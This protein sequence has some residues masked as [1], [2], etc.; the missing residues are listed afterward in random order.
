VS[1]A[2]ALPII[3]ACIVAFT[4]LAYIVLDGFDLGL[5]ILFAAERGPGARDVLVNTVAPVWDGNETWLVL[6]GACLYGVFPIAYGTILP[7]LYPPIIA[8]LLALIFRGVA[9]E[10]RFK[11]H[12]QRQRALWDLSFFAGSTVAAAMQGIILG[13]LIQGIEV[14]NR[15]YAGGWFDWLT[16]FSLVC[17]FAVVV[18]Y[19]LLGACWLVWRTEG[20]LQARARGYAKP[21]A[22]ITVAMIIVVSLWTP[23]LHREYLRHWYVWP[24][25]LY[26]LPV[27][28]LVAALVVVFWRNITD[29]V[30][31]LTP[32][33]CV[34]GWF[35]LCFTG[36][37]ISIWPWIVPPSID[38]WQAASP[39][40]SQWFLLVGAAVLIPVVLAYTGYAYWIF[41]GK[42]GNETHYH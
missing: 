19:A 12:T 20:V 29:P 25:I 22:A 21:L 28:V 13:G 36:L 3:W 31:H 41:R 8:M 30:V 10:F 33:L 11:V 16:A 15:Q 4:V 42:V 38:I 1:T 26:V 7:A 14:E 18:G 17:G 34:L 23:E 9:F 35:F 32:L 6:G 2:H 24:R 37:G 39:L 27:P 5:G 40:S